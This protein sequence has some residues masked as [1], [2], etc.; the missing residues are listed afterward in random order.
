M[1]ARF[2]LHVLIAGA[3]A[4]PALEGC[5]TVRLTEPAQTATEQLLVTS[6]VDRAVAK[7]DPHIPPGTR[8]FVDAQYFDNGAPTSQTKYAIASIRDRLLHLGVN[9]VADRGAADT[10]VEVRTGGQSIDHRDQLL[11]IPALPVPIP[12]TTTVITT[13][14]LP[15][16]EQ[17]RQTGIAKLAL[18]AYDKNTGALT[19][20]SGPVYG[21]SRKSH[22]VVLLLISGSKDDYV[23]K[24]VPH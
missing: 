11:G 19:S 5:S 1:R 20:S 8:V 9:L 10:V 4:L 13:P 12:L 3:L 6:A 7:L 2:F 15:I 23:P 22:W 14:K 21:T 18:T 16:Y 17:D 24:G